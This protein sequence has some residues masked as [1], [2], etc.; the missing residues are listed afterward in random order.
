MIRKAVC[1]CVCVC[2]HA[3]T[4]ILSISLGDNLCAFIKLLFGASRCGILMQKTKA[5]KQLHQ[6]RVEKVVWGVAGMKKK[7]KK[8]FCGS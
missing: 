6:L 3:H 8:Y 4:W 1:V 5:G 2:L 7:F